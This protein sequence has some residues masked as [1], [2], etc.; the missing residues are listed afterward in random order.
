MMDVSVLIPTHPELTTPFLGIWSFCAAQLLNH[1][2]PMS[3]YE[4]SYR[5]L[6]GWDKRL[7]VESYI[8]ERCN[9]IAPVW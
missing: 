6:L 4:I 8:H 9:I 1:D 3:E 7:T 5:T 2:V